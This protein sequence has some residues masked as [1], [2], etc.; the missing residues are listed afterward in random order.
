MSYTFGTFFAFSCKTCQGV[1]MKIVDKVGIIVRLKE[2]IAEA[3][4]HNKELAQQLQKLLD[5]ILRDTKN[6]P[7][8]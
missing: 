6:S 7:A 1:C 3:Q 4:G 5:N 2:K 8:I